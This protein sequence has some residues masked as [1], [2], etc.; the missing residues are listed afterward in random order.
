MRGRV[1]TF[2]FS[3]FLAVLGVCCCMQAFCSCGEQGYCVVVVGGLLIGVA[4]HCGA[5][6]LRFMGFRSCCMW[7]Q[8]LWLKGCRAQTHWLWHRRSCLAADR[9]FLDQGSN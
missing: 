5:Q 4:S 2:F 6:V 1:L 9:I 3:F 8:Q 7:A